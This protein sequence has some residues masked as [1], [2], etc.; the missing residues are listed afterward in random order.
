MHLCLDIQKLDT[1]E[2]PITAFIHSSEA[3]LAGAEATKNMQ[4]QVSS[5]CI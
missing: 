2:N 1:G 4:A 3:A 5:H